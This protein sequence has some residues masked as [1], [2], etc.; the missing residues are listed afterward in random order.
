MKPPARKRAKRSLD[1]PACPVPVPVYKSARLWMGRE[2]RCLLSSLD[3]LRG[4]PLDPE[5]I[6]ERVSSRS[7]QEISAALKDLKD[8][9]VILAKHRYEAEQQSEPRPL[10]L[11]I[12]EASAVSGPAVEEALSS[13]F[14]QMLTV[15]S[16]EPQTLQGKCTL[17]QVQSQS[18]RVQHNVSFENIYQHLSALHQPQHLQRKL[19]PMESAVLLDLLL[20][21]P[22]EIEELD[23][24]QVYQ[25]LSRRD[26][27]DGPPGARLKPTPVLN[28]LLVPV[29]L[30]TRKP[31]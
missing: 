18:R 20:S 3:G 12:Q 1:P 22:E 6:R 17:P 28:P 4:A 10:E 31:T 5:K 21:L 14:C 16:T 7:V 9:V 29:H 2:Q 27:V 24:E 19:S 15:A 8:Q 30:L 26:Q 23:S 25:F 13:A 11:W